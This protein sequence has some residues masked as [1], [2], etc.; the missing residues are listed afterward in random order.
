MKHK[1]RR[2]AALFVM[3]MVL[4]TSLPLSAMAQGSETQTTYYG[5]VDLASTYEP[6]S[7]LKDSF[8]FS[9]EWFEA[10]PAETNDA[11]A[12]VSMQ[13]TAAV[14]DGDE[15]GSGTA[16]LRKMGFSNIKYYNFDSDNPDD[17][18]FVRAEKP[19][20]SGGRLVAV[21]IQSYSLDSAVKKK[22]WTQ[23]FVVNGDPVED[24]H[25]AFAKAAELAMNDVQ[26]LADTHTKYWVMGQSRGGAIANLIAKRLPADYTCAYTF[27]SPA[28]TSEADAG[29][30]E[31][32]YIH[33]YLC[34]DDP[35]TMIP[36]WGMT[37]YGQ[38]HSIDRS[39]DIKD[40]LTKLQSKA[41]SVSQSGSEEETA[42][43][44][45]AGLEENVPTR[46]AYST[47]VE[48]PDGSGETATYQEA[49]ANFM[50]VI[51]GGGLEGLNA[52]SLLAR[53]NE[54]V[55]LLE[56]LSKAV[57]EQKAGESESSDQDFWTAATGL[58]DFLGTLL[59]EGRENPLLVKD[60]YM[61]LKMAGDQMIDEDVALD[62]DF[63][64]IMA[65]EPILTLV[66]EKNSL[67]YS[68]QFDTLIARLK[69]MSPSPQLEDFD[70]LMSPPA[71][72]DSADKAISE[73]KENIAPDLSP[74]ISWIGSDT[75]LQDNRI[76][77]LQVLLHVPGRTVDGFHM[78][79]NGEAP[80]EDPDISYVDGDYIVSG[81]WSYTLGNPRKVNV[82]F[83]TG[84][85]AETPD[86]IEVYAGSLLGT[87]AAGQIT[88]P[89]V[90]H[91]DGKSYKF[92]G[93]YLDGISWE[94][95]RA[96]DDLTLTA[97]W[98]Q[99]ID[100]ID[101]SVTYP[102]VGDEPVA[103]TVPADAEYR[104]DSWEI[105]DEKYEDMT[106]A[107]NKQYTFDIEIVSD[108]VAFLDEISDSIYV[109]NVYLGEIYVNGQEPDEISYSYDRDEQRG[110]IY[111]SKY[112]TPEYRKTP[113]ASYLPLKL[114]AIRKLKNQITLQ[115]DKT[116]EAASYEIYGTRLGSW[117]L[118]KLAEVE[119]QNMYTVKDLLT[120]AF[121]KFYVAAKDEYGNVVY[122]S[123]TIY[124]RTSAGKS[125]GKY[126]QQFGDLRK[127][128][129]KVKAASMMAKQKLSQ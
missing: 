57:K 60:I 70:V 22:G 56:P 8:Y 11:L 83:D 115:W 86:P 28:V 6:G 98:K 101:I 66:S 50:G 85:I 12:L 16:M 71:A 74:E 34:G 102:N 10:D 13:L 108:D 38:T 75:V 73:L 116:D 18:A 27:E 113:A 114:R 91:A 58:H 53:L 41:G 69:T 61:V 25:Y 129:L 96:N 93:W 77:Y 2:F 17:C 19:L 89:G 97:A 59:P 5:T 111:V 65:L 128:A 64:V 122:K 112:F 40:L 105:Y 88:D 45:I 47:P 81:V 100:R 84:G 67:V 36:P 31:Y 39:A 21:I 127:V 9:D 118:D 63:A 123:S 20:A 30:E 3:A 23:N 104:I 35:V 90:A 29:R 92:E 117:T 82:S 99:V 106:I 26:D 48:I 4:V 62:N 110:R 119:D 54:L 109:D 124:A 55:P 43:A 107:L 78:T 79:I 1:W 51:F 103:P 87:E 49:M 94:E 125:T 52:M 33:N 7:V 72:Q 14:A 126:S 68:H 95:V 37:R 76:Y 32:N 120:G 44:M 121:Y 15:E 80:M 42:R 46:E 24:E